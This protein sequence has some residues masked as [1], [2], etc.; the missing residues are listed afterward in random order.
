MHTHTHRSQRHSRT[1]LVKAEENL[2][3][4]EQRTL[5]ETIATYTFSLRETQLANLRIDG[6]RPH[7]AWRLFII[8]GNT[9]KIESREAPN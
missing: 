5:Q 8:L 4:Y 3:E 7:Q 9:V 1:C 6:S 2:F